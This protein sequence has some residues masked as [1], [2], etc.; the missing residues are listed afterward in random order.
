MNEEDDNKEIMEELAAAMQNATNLVEFDAMY[1]KILQ[2]GVAV[3]NW[4]NYMLEQ[5][6]SEEWCEIAAM[7]ILRALI[8]AD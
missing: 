8:G 6:F 3:A 7:Q 5:D 4:R 2:I 1:S